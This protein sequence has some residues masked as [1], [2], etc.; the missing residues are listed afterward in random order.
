MAASVADPT[1]YILEDGA[2]T[3]AY[4]PVAPVTRLKSDQDV[5]E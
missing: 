4:R 2:V 5:A 1:P 3:F